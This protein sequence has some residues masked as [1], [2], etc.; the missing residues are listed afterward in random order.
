M[1]YLALILCLVYFPVSGWAMEIKSNAFENGKILSSQYTCDGENISPGLNWDGVP[2]E[3]KTL[4]L[5]CDDPD[6]LAKPWSHWVIFNLPAD[7][8]NL[9]QGISPMDTSIMQ[10]INDFGEPGYSGPCPPGEKP[11]RYF[12]KLYA[13]DTNLSLEKNVTKEV[14]LEAMQGHILAQAEIFCT[15]QRRQ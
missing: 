13:L 9:A 8:V 3:T 11:H 7:K 4:A 15:Y 6:S 14:L 10:G 5:I 2:S 12:F 1:R